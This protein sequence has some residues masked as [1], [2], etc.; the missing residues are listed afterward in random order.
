M[1]LPGCSRHNS[2]VIT[3]NHESPESTETVETVE[4]NRA[5]FTNKTSYKEWKISPDTII[6]KVDNIPVYWPEFHFWLNY[7]KKYYKRYHKLNKITDW[8]VEQNGMSLSEFF[9]SSAVG[10]ACKGRAIEAKAEELGIKLS[11]DDLAEIEKKRESDIKIYSRP[12][13]LRIVRKMYA[14]EKVFNY[15]TKIDYL[16]KYVFKYFYGANGE[17]C[18]SEDVSAYVK[19]KS[20]M[21]A[22]YIFL[23]NSD[24]D[25]ND[26]STEER[27][28][29]YKLLENILGR[30]DASEAPLTLFDTLMNDY[31]KDTTVSISL[32]GRLFVSGS[33]GKEFENA[34]LK[35]KENEYSRIIKTGDGYYIVLRMPI[36]PDMTVDGNTLRYNT[37]YEYLFKKQI[38]SWYAK[39]KIKHEEAYYKIDIKELPDN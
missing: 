10:Y 39:M 36:S 35:L 32:Y 14:S 24:T 23:P 7:I 12:E 4:T 20:Y 28:K 21:C 17:K 2:N 5:E 27:T 9:L 11:K 30:L 29:N 34:C 25:N 37:A 3:S 33:I 22:K 26:L 1:T 18:S 6:I 31:S 15:L 13:Y 8:T 16:T 38:E 19:E